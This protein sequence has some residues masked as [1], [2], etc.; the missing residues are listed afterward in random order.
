MRRELALT[1]AQ[2]FDYLCC[3][4]SVS[5]APA[6]PLSPDNHLKYHKKPRHGNHYYKRGAAFVATSTTTIFTTSFYT[7]SVTAATPPAIT[8][9]SV[10]FTTIPVPFTA[11]TTSTAPASQAT[12]CSGTVRAPP[13]VLKVEN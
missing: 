9:E 13:H 6:K 5:A 11:T 4:F 7:S 12:D 2:E 3:P 8:T 10:V 1:A